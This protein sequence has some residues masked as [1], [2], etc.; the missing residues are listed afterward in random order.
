MPRLCSCRGI[1]FFT[2]AHFRAAAGTLVR[3]V[4]QTLWP[5][6]EKSCY[7]QLLRVFAYIS[8]TAETI[9]T[10]RTYI[11]VYA[12]KTPFNTGINNQRLVKVFQREDK[13]KFFDEKVVRVFRREGTLDILGRLPG[14]PSLPLTHTLMCLLLGITLVPN[15]DVNIF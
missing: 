14:A 1:V 11:H 8:S 4:H 12:C 10:H 6:K 2:H 13:S 7:R 5:T 9:E 15:P 3:P